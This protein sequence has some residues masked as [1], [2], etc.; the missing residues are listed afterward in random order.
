MANN[1][2][3]LSLTHGLVWDQCKR[4]QGYPVAISESHEQA[5]VS[6]GDR[7]VFRRMLA[8]SLERQ[9]LSSAT[10]QKDRSKRSPWV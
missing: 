9:N 1:E 10:S 7:R 4:G 3:L 6:T 8:D 2:V 5:V